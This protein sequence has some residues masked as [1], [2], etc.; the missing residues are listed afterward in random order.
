MKCCFDLVI[1]IYNAALALISMTEEREQVATEQPP[2]LEHILQCVG[3]GAVGGLMFSPFAEM[4]LEQF[5][6]SRGWSTLLSTAAGAIVLG[7]AA[8]NGYVNVEKQVETVHAQEDPY[9]GVSALSR[10]LDVKVYNTDLLAVMQ[11]RITRA[12]AYNPLAQY[13]QMYRQH[14]N[15]ILADHFGVFEPLALSHRVIDPRA[16]LDEFFEQG[17]TLHRLITERVDQL[18]ADVAA[19]QPLADPA[20]YVVFKDEVRKEVGLARDVAVWASK[21]AESGTF[22]GNRVRE[23]LYKVGISDPSALPGDI[24]NI[25]LNAA[26]LLRAY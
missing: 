25:Y 10:K 8:K 18:C 5:D 26:R 21:L 15:G 12:L 20:W 23:K 2:S 7:I 22:A 9:P 14:R 16:T 24:D 13:E 6:I 19:G 17:N 3:V 1:K 11:N 4:M